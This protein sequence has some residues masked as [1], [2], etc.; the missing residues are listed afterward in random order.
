MYSGNRL[1]II[2]YIKIEISKLT[3]NDLIGKYKLHR[4]LSIR[5]ELKFSKF[6]KH[7]D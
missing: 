6:E 4:A 3:Y 2:I 5:L 1:K 7:K